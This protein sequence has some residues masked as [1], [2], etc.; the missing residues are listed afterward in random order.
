MATENITAPGVEKKQQVQLAAE[1]TDASPKVET[2]QQVQYWLHVS[3]AILVVLLVLSAIGVGITD[4]SPQHSWKYW[5]SMVPI[6]GTLSFLGGWSRVRRRGQSWWVMLRTQLLHWGA[7]LVAVYMIFLLLGAGRLDNENTG[8]VALL[9]LSLT[10]F[11]AGVHFDWRFCLVGAFLAV[12]LIMA[13]WVEEYVWMM[14]IFAV[15]LVLV[16]LLVGRY[17][18]HRHAGKTGHPQQPDHG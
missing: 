14:L 5:L 11:L 15:L 8:L 12:T 16:G 1:N 18:I 10:T 13:A 9:A 3:E 7:L 4:F 2:K 17:M 6:F